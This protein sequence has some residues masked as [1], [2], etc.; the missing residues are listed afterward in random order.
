MRVFGQVT[1]D[2][3]SL[4]SLLEII[5]P[6][7]YANPRIIPMVAYS[8]RREACRCRPLIPKLYIDTICVQGLVALTERN[9]NKS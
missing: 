2:F 6:V 1:S 9:Q 5:A 4:G 8:L 7:T 3:H